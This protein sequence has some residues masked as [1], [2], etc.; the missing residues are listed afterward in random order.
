MQVIH[1]DQ[2]V[3]VCQYFPNPNIF[4]TPLIMTFSLLIIALEVWAIFLFSILWNLHVFH[5]SFLLLFLRASCVSLIFFLSI[6]PYL[7]L[8]YENFREKDS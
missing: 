2:N 7:F 6:A 8:A 3:Q 5:F 4:G 1:F